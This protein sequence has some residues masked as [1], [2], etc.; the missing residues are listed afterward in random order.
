MQILKSSNHI[1]P[2]N[3]LMLSEIVR[4]CPSSPI[5]DERELLELRQNQ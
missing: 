3:R 1:P 2:F 5:F 4:G